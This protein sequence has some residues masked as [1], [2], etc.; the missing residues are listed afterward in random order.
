MIS[1]FF[2]SDELLD[3][4]LSALETAFGD[5]ENS[6]QLSPPSEVFDFSR[7]QLDGDMLRAFFPEERPSLWLVDSDLF[8]PGTN[9]VFGFAAEKRAVLSTF[10]LDKKTVGAEAVHEV[11]HTLGLEHCE[12]D[13]VMRFA[14]SLKETCS[15]SP[16]LCDECKRKL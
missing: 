13:C 12:N 5:V 10:R 1:V 15:R 8:L 11:G 14:N 9:F 4:V 3:E 6:G 16:F 7:D 2:E